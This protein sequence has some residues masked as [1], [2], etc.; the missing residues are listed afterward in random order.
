MPIAKPIRAALG[1]DPNLTQIVE[2]LATIANTLAE[3]AEPPL[4]IYHRDIKPENLYWFND[5]WCIGDFGLVDFP[6]KEEMTEAGRVLGPRFY[7]APE[8]LNNPHPQT[9]PADVFSLA[10]TLWVLATNYVLPLPGHLR[11]D[12][13]QCRLSSFVLGQNTRPLEVLIHQSTQF[14]PALRPTMKEFAAEL[15]AWL[16]PT[17]SSSGTLP[18][19]ELRKRVLPAIATRKDAEMR[20]GS[21]QNYVMSMMTEMNKRI[22]RIGDD[23][24]EVTGLT[25]DFSG[26]ISGFDNFPEILSFIHSVADKVIYRY[27]AMLVH[28]PPIYVGSQTRIVDWMAGIGMIATVSGEMHLFAAH[29]TITRKPGAPVFRLIWL[30][31]DRG[32]WNQ[33]EKGKLSRNFLRPYMK[34]FL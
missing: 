29:G 17:V 22:R 33:Q 14:D 11:Y 30:D 18:I 25:P 28:S 10:K 3:L 5:E 15:R 32:K 4:E 7:H 8:L 2:A 27:D 12:E 1:T 9:G 26:M 23:V 20:R 31:G 21:Q 6:D 19:E 16:N 24:R 34:L 13:D